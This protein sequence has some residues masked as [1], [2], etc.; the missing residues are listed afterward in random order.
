[1]AE[2][3][4]EKLLWAKAVAGDREA[5]NRLVDPLTEELL[6]AAR[7]EL[8]YFT[9][10]GDIPEDATT[11]H[12]IVAEVLL[13][14]WRNRRRRIPEMRL[15]AW[16]LAI[17]YR[18]V[19]EIAARERRR[20]RIAEAAADFHPDVPPLEDP[21]G[22]WEWFQPEDTPVGEPLMPEEPRDP[23][24]LVSA[25]ERRPRVLATTARR[26]LLLYRRHG[27]RVEEVGAILRKPGTETRRL[28]E[29]AARRVREELK[30]GRG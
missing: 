9:A 19:D 7:R 28:I 29:D 17:L 27:L 11:P 20:E 16:L 1:M 24:T 4:G 30:A 25:L 8:D 10:V 21:E 18:V 23:E 22:F 13:R 14:A 2:E 15:K 6:E 3:A 5:F 26:A 12:D